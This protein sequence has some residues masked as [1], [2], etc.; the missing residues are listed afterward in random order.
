MLRRLG[1]VLLIATFTVVGIAMGTHGSTPAG[2]SVGATSSTV[3]SEMP[4]DHDHVMPVASQVDT[5]VSVDE[6]SMC[7]DCAGDHAALLMACV[8]L[9][10]LVVISLVL[11]VVAFRFGLLAPGVSRLDTRPR[12]LAEPRP[13][14]LT[15]LCIIRQ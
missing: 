7:V 4:V 3:G 10:L 2:H 9:A 1:Y 8:F 12:R 11:P 15:E 14:D 13:P 5:N 6:N